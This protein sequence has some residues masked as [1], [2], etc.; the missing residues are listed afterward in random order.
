MVRGFGECAAAVDGWVDRRVVALI[1][2]EFRRAVLFTVQ[3]CS[4]IRGKLRGAIVVLP[5]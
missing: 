4:S 3:Y 2:F 5:F 1:K